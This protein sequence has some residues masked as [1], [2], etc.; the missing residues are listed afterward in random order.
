MATTFDFSTKRAAISGAALSVP[1]FY[2][3]IK[4]AQATAEGILYP[5]IA[6]AA[7]DFDLGAGRRSGLIV[8]LLDSWQAVFAPGAYQAT[9]DDGVLIGGVA[10]QPIAYSAGV[11]AILNRPADAFGVATGGADANAVAAA[12]LAALNATAIPVDVQRING[13]EIYGSGSDADPMRETP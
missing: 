8:E 4:A 3:E 5:P 6:R 2:D 12:V 7:G 13:R 11:Q 9:V 1:S 10:Q